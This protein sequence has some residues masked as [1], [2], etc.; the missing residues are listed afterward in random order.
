[1][2]VLQP[3][4]MAAC[5]GLVAGVSEAAQVLVPV[6]GPNN[7][8]ESILPV[9]LGA[10]SSVTV[11]FDDQAISALQTGYYY[12]YSLYAPVP[13]NDGSAGCYYGLSGIDGGPTTF[14]WTKSGS[15]KFLEA[16]APQVAW[17]PA[18]HGFT[19]TL[20][21]AKP[22]LPI[23][24]GGSCHE[25]DRIYG[26]GLYGR[27]STDQP[28]TFEFSYGAAVPQAVPEPATWAMMI[29]GFGLVGS[30]LRRR[31]AIAA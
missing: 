24:Q 13:C 17:T 22:C 27:A 3:A 15:E 19:L 21:P 20:Y 1:M 11:T 4:A 16:P 28:V 26:L 10:G 2:R 31:P 18:A 7:T 5:F 6:I 30:T 8:F 12:K 25:I 23:A 29:A 9:S 14:D